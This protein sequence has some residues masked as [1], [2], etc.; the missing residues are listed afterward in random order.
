MPD[1]LKIVRQCVQEPQFDTET[2]LEKVA[3]AIVEINVFL[4]SQVRSTTDIISV[5]LF[6]SSIRN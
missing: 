1:V 3:R 4:A 5:D 2:D 6:D